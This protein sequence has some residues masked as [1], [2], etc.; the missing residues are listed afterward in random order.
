MI[1]KPE[2]DVAYDVVKGEFVVALARSSNESFLSEVSM[3][4]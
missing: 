1:H 3:D 2:D 4:S